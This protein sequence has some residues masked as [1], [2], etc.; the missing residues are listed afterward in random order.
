LSLFTIS[1]GV[2]AG[3]NSPC[4]PDATSTPCTP[5]SASVLISGSAGRR[6]GPITAKAFR[7]PAWMCDMVVAESNM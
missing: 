4:Q 5:S 2:P 7:R 3:A 6:L 1:A